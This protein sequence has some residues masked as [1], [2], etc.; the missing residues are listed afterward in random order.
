MELYKTPMVVNGAFA[1][2]IALKYLLFS[3]NIQY[4]K[5]HRICIAPML[6]MNA[7][8]YI[9]TFNNIP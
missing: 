7:R 6:P 5:G 3:K 1:T 8:I 2:E 4:K 9:K